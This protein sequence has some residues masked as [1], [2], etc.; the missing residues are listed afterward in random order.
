[1][2]DEDIPLKYRA[3]IIMNNFDFTTYLHGSLNLDA[4]VGLTG[5]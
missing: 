2:E 1:M 4:T 3:C 5:L